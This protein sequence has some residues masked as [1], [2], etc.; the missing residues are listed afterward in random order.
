M[1]TKRR[2]SA[3]A[4]AKTLAG[5]LTAQIV[6]GKETQRARTRA[7]LCRDWLFTIT[8][9]WP[10]VPDGLLRQTYDTARCFFDLPLMKSCK[11]R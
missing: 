4:A 7:G 8:I 10:G 3:K 6:L 9:V 1:S 11:C 5:L 2:R